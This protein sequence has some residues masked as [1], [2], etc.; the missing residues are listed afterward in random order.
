MSQTIGFGLEWLAEKY[1]AE[2]GRGAWAKRMAEAAERRA[3]GISE[4]DA[5]C[6]TLSAPGTKTNRGFGHWTCDV[7]QAAQDLSRRR[8]S[9]E[10]AWE[11]IPERYRDDAG[12]RFGPKSQEVLD[13]PHDATRNIVVYGPAGAGKTVVACAYLTR[14]LRR[15]EETGDWKGRPSHARFVSS[16]RLARARSEHRL[17]GGEA[18]LVKAALEASTLVL[19]DLGSEPEVRDSAVPEVVYERH[20]EGLRTVITTSFDSWE[21][22]AARYGDG[23]ARRSWQGSKVLGLPKRGGK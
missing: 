5:H 4:C 15:A 21:G 6:G 8:R 20:C 19:D 10:S 22:L 2:Y 23:I 17:G 14:W 12:L 16:Y 7:C 11:T 3:Q 9:T 18:P 13:E 1:D